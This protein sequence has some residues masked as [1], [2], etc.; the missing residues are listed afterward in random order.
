MKPRIFLLSTDRGLFA[1]VADVVR[2]MGCEAF[3]S[4]CI[5]GTINF[6]TELLRPGD[7]IIV[8]F[9]THGRGFAMLDAVQEFNQQL[10]CIAVTEPG[11]DF[12]QALALINGATEVFAKPVDARDLCRAVMQIC[13]HGFRS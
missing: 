5:S 7:I 3:G 6:F 12:C 10:P 8:D 1:V 13:E 9:G 4:E 11:A 2:E